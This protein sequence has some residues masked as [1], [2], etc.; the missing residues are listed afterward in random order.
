[1]RRTRIVATIGPASRDPEALRAM[2]RAG[3]DVARLNFSHGDREEK[4]ALIAAVREAAAAEGRPVAVLQDLAGPKIRIGEI[5]AGTVTLQEGQE[6]VL[7]ARDVPGDEHAVSLVYRD[8]PRDVR[9]GE[10]LLLADGA[11]ELRVEKVAGDDIHCRVVTGGPL[12]S[13]KGINLPEGTISAPILDEKDEADLRF[14]LEHGVDYVALSFVRDADDVRAAR[15]VMAEAGRNVPIIA[16]IE[17]RQGVRN[18]DA[19]LAEADGL[20]VAR[21][22]LGVEI[23]LAEV[24]RVQ[25]MLVAR[26]NAAAKPVITATQMLVS[27]VTSPRPTRAEVS[28]VANAILDG[29][30]AV[31]LS[32]ETAVGRDPARVIAV[33]GDIAREAEA[34][35]PHRWWETRFLEAH[36]TAGVEA[37]VAR[38]ACAMAGE[39]GAAAIVTPTRSGSTARLVARCRP[40]RP[41]VALTDDPDTERRLCLVWGVVPLRI[42]STDSM[43]ELERLALRRAVEAEVLAPGQRVI[44][45]AGVPLGRAGGTNMIRVVSVPGA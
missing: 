19:I 38:A 30:D 10:R 23:P 26:A 39:L 8:L 18:I 7:T 14:G 17:Q 20:M 45:T 11:L 32:E 33:M 25:K 6:F 21:G 3:L 40:P 36:G 2:V 22:D 4:A 12:S 24:P 29:S 16:K 35:F 43:E 31:M 5:A 27:M 42:P 1:V 37:S 34:I 15:R 28:D 13:H 9:P 41:I 44:V